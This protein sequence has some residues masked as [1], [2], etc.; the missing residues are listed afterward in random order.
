MRFGTFHLFQWHESK[1]QAQVYAEVIEQ[2]Q[3]AE[4]L[5]FE[6]VW[7]AE[8]HFSPYCLCPAILPTAAHLAALTKRVRIG[9]AV[10]VLPFYD[11][12]VV[13]EETAT[14]DILSGGRFEFGVG[15]GYQW[16]E[17]AGFNIPLDEARARFDE[18]LAIILK[19][20]TE[21]AVQYEGRFRTLRGVRILPK[22]IQKPHPPVWTATVSPEGLEHAGR[23]GSNI[24][25]S[26]SQSLGHLRRGLAIYREALAAAGHSFH[27]GRVRLVRPTFVHD[28][29]DAAVAMIEPHYRWFLRTQQAAVTPPEGRWDLIPDHYRHYRENF[30]KLHRVDMATVRDEIAVWGPPARCVERIGLLREQLGIDYMICQFA[31]GGMEQRAVLRA[32]ERFATEVMPAFAAAPAAAAPRDG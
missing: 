12:V 4:A 10:M 19:A 26:Q 9:T 11:P 2:V 15:R 13:A 20:W 3:L 18:S 17:F 25:M 14:V 8:H 28:D 16:L 7:L 31:Y 5:G 32:M 24:L 22:P 30:P 27:A 23:R 29:L 6:S 1:S 21:E